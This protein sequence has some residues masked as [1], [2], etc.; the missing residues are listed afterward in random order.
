MRI[1]FVCTGNMCRSPLAERLT[2]SWAEQ[3][4]GA[5]AAMVRVHSAGTDA[6]EGRAMDS[7]SAQV[8]EELGGTADAFASRLLVP[9]DAQSADLVLTMSRRHRHLLLKT[10]PRALR[11]TFTLLEAVSLLEHTDVRGIEALP[12]DERAGELAARLNAGRSR[13]RADPQD[14]VPDPVGR[15]L[16]EHRAVGRQIADALDRLVEPL[17]A[18]LVPSRAPR[19]DWQ[20]HPAPLP[21]LPHASASRRLPPVASA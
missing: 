14:D 5:S 13:R 11:R 7:R 17:F 9:A 21:P 3:R 18:P 1:L 6:R 19:P 2:S 8:L 10:A 15:P 12:F 16:S 4:L 20:S